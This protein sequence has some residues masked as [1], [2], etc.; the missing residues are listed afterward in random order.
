[1][2]EIGLDMSRFPTS[3][4]LAAWASMAPGNNES[5]GKRLSGTTRKGSPWLR[6]ALVEA[7]HGAGHSKGNYLSAQYQRLVTRRGKKKA[8]V[9]VGHSIL[10][11][12]YH[13]LKK[14]TSYIDLGA[15]Y[16]DERGRDLI[17]RRLVHRLERLGYKVELQ[18][19]A[20]V[21]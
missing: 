3:G 14:G 7:A 11:V 12:S 20:A 17:Q 4:H 9:A 1:M 19:V 21:A 18:P 5:A 10:V 15:N 13:L 2:A 16:F 8:A 6:S